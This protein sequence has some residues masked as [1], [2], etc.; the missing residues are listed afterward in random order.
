MA[1]K[2][3]TK[4]R[5]T[6]DTV[7][8]AIVS[9]PAG[10]YKQ[11]SD[12][13][14]PGLVLR[15]RKSGSA[16][17]GYYRKHRNI[18][19]TP[20]RHDLGDVENIT[21]RS[22][23]AAAGELAAELIKGIDRRAIAAEKQAEKKEQAAFDISLRDALEE[24]L[25]I[26]YKESTASKY[27]TLIAKHTGTFWEYADKPMRELTPDLVLKLHQARQRPDKKNTRRPSPSLANAHCR[28]LKAVWNQTNR[29]LAT[30]DNPEPL[31][32]NPVLKLSDK[33][34]GS[35]GRHWAHVP[36]KKSS[37]QRNQLADWF[38]ACRY[39]QDSESLTLSTQARACEIL[40]TTGL[41]LNEVLKAKWDWFHSADRL[42]VVPDTDNK[43]RKPIER[44]LTD[45]QVELIELQAGID[46][47][48]I[49]PVA[50]IKVAVA[51]IE[52]KTGLR[53]TANDLKRT[54]LS[55]SPL[56]GNS[57]VI[58][59]ALINHQAR[60]EEVT[61]GYMYF[62]HDTLRDAAEAVERLIY[63][64][65]GLLENRDEIDALLDSMPKSRKRKLL[66]RLQK[67]LAA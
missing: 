52:G 55:H 13:D 51:E 8:A 31:G 38:V 67:E 14:Q 17:F 19:A 64:N 11:F 39:A 65:A 1:E 32:R 35:T 57:D 46:A 20:I 36:R 12:T 30:N 43:S 56:A 62:D 49:F 50:D 34:P 42:L 44:P 47:E 7:A 45:R 23:R 48:R 9:V 59:K 4:F 60:T 53:R 27:R 37:V 58:T 66:A 28:Y 54:F 18:S 5:F 26:G 15:V 63:E 25:A 21:I 2:H 29:R 22:A 24:V 61:Q 40:I 41:R 16:S 10:D 6:K 33:K 3:S